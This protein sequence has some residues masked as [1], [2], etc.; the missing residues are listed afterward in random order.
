MTGT[1]PPGQMEHRAVGMFVAAL[2]ILASALVAVP[3]L[4]LLPL[5]YHPLCGFVGTMAAILLLFASF[6]LY[7]TGR[8]LGIIRDGQNTY[9]LSRLQMAGWTWVII[10]ALIAAAAAR[11]WHGGSAASGALNIYIPANLFIVMGISF[12][13]GAAAPAILSLKTQA[14]PT[15]GQIETARSRMAE[16]NIVAN[17]QIVVRQVTGLPLLGDI[18][19][20]DDLATAGTVDVSK[21]QQLLITGLLVMVY[22]AMLWN[23]FAD[24]HVTGMA[25]ELRIALIKRG[26]LLCGFDDATAALAGDCGAAWTAM[27][28]FSFSM[29]ALLAVSHGGYLAYKIAPRAAANAAGSAM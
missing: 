18:I 5:K 7:V 12:F 2:L 19:S 9:S 28:D 8:P 21:V 24:A 17:G 15:Q 11:L 10:S 26:D 13:T 14:A 16:P 3:W 29:T 20:G 23:L 27:P 4:G 22:V 1:A 6:G 25:E